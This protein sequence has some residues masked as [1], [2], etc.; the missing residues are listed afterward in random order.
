MAFDPKRL[1]NWFALS[2]VAIVLVVSGFYLYARW[3][4]HH[5]IQHVAEKLHVDIQQSTEGFT[6]SKSEGGRTLFSIHAKRA[7]QFKQG[8]RAVLHEVNKPLVIEELELDPQSSPIPARTCRFAS[9]SRVL[10]L[11]KPQG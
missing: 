7:E 6:L 11:A 8:G 1:R 5:A 2:A 9:G 4:I 3:R 10:D